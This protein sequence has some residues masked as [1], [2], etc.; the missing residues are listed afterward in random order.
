MDENMD[1]N[2]KID[3]LL[4]ALTGV[5]Q[6][7]DELSER[8]DEHDSVLYDGLIGPANEQIAQNEYDNALSDFRTKYAEKLGPYE[9]KLKAIEGDDFDVFKEAFDTYNDSDYDFT[10]DEYVEKL[11]A[12]ISDQIEKIKEAVAEQEGV[13]KEDVEV[14]VD[15]SNGEVQVDVDNKETEEKPEDNVT[16]TEETVSDDTENTEADDTDELKEF[17]DSLKKEADSDKKSW[18]RG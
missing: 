13:D 8:V 9:G 11:T 6:K 18:I 4:E 10:P 3:R 16:E 1:L 15:A 12:S 5:V 2:T 17:E 7:V 14:E